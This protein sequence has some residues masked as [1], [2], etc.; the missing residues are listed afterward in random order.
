MPSITSANG[1]VLRR[2]GR[3]NVSLTTAFSNG[4]SSVFA[5]QDANYGFRGYYVDQSEYN[6]YFREGFRRGYENG[7]N[8]RY[9]YGRRSNGTYVVLASILV[10][11][12]VFEA[13]TND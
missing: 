1:S 5:Y 12:L 8:S 4:T 10:G 11:I 7:Y 3:K 9:R 6:Y 2:S 13:L